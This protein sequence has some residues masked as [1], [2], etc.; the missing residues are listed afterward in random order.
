MFLLL[1]VFDRVPL[2]FELDG[3]WPEWRPPLHAE[4][5]I[6]LYIEDLLYKDNLQRND[7]GSLF[8]FELPHVP[9]Q[10]ANYPSTLEEFIAFHTSTDRETPAADLVNKGHVSLNRVAQALL[11]RG[12]KRFPL[13]E[14]AFGVTAWKNG[15]KNS[16]TNIFYCFNDEADSPTRQ[17]DEH[18]YHKSIAWIN[19]DGVGYPQ[20]YYKDTEYK[21]LP[22]AT[23]SEIRDHIP[24]FCSIFE[25]QDCPW[26]AQKQIMALLCNSLYPSDHASCIKSLTAAAAPAVFR[27]DGARAPICDMGCLSHLRCNSSCTPDVKRG[28]SQAAMSSTPLASVMCLGAITFRT[29]A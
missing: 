9:V 19:V 21:H 27:C 23:A 5:K 8:Y 12:N 11:V 4:T 3:V 20:I 13:L 22:H 1:I 16:N 2:M 29:Q 25:L 7:A 17:P 15:I 14:L 24:K 28:D 18:L 10:V 6:K 26:A